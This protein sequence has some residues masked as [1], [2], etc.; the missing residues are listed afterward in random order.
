MAA[1]KK[2][3]LIVDDNEKN[4]KY[5]RVVLQ[6]TGYG[7]LEAEDGE[8]GVRLARE[9]LPAVILMDVRMPRMDGI[10]ATRILKS[11]S[12]TSKIPVVIT[13]S[14]AMKGN[15]EKI[16]SETGCDDYI[17]KPVEINT[18]LSAVK[19]YAGE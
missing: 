6:K 4:R 9:N 15:R 3:I 17:T 19:R 8:Q 1:E 16:V 11:D 14:S 12:A 18:L 13:T 7:V 10:E 5:L 2:L